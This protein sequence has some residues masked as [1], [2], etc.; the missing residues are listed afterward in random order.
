ME[1]LAKSGAAGNAHDVPPVMA[2]VE[3]AG[4]ETAVVSFA[5]P[6][7]RS[8]QGKIMVYDVFAR[9]R[10]ER[11]D[12]GEPLR[13]PTGLPVAEPTSEMATAPRTAAAMAFGHLYLTKTASCELRLPEDVA[14][15]AEVTDIEPRTRVLHE[16]AAGSSS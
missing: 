11:N 2:D 8:W 16:H 3:L 13:T 5:Y 12:R 1:G 4:G 9:V 14:E 15:S 6:I 7:A 10:Y